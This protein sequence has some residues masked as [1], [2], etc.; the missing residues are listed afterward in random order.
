MI[1]ILPS[2]TAQR[3]PQSLRQTWHFISG[4]FTKVAHSTE[5]TQLS[6]R[7]RKEARVVIANTATPPELVSMLPDAMQ[8]LRKDTQR[9]VATRGRT[10]SVTLHDGSAARLRMYRRGGL[11]RYIN[12]DVFCGQ[13][14]TSRLLREL[15]ILDFLA[16]KGIPVVEPL[17]GYFE[18]VFVGLYRCMIATREV[19]EA[20]TLLAFWQSAGATKELV[21][22]HSQEVAHSVRRMIALGVHHCDL[23]P[24]NVLRDAKGELRII[25]FDKASLHCWESGDESQRRTLQNDYVKRW[26]RGCNKHLTAAQAESAITA[27]RNE[28]EAAA[29]ARSE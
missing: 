13:L 3:L 19:K 12:A 27:F 7:T 1:R 15:Q 28:L 6:Q 14:S 2:D 26:T 29:D 10:M 23:Y 22:Q 16:Q 5:S 11:L 24:G 25:D 20:T 9:G 17:G 18:R 4:D 8:E 21:V